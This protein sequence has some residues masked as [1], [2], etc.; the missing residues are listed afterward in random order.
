VILDQLEMQSVAKHY[1]ERLSVSEHLRKLLKHGDAKQFA[2][3]ALGIS[4]P[5]ANYSAKEHGLGPRILS[6]VRPTAVL[7][8]ATKLAQSATPLEMVESIYRENIPYL[9]ISVGSEIAMMI[10]P[11]K[12]WV[13]NTRSVWAHLLV[14]HKFDYR[15]ANEELKL[16]RD[17]DEDSEMAYKKWKAI[18]FEMRSN[19]VELGRRVEKRAAKQKISVGAA[20]N[21]WFDAIANALYEAK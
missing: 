16:Y 7:N 1:D 6:A 11:E 19:L 4:E 3:V 10:E 12:F 8:L 5:H 9:K 17:D 15:K 18:Y 2:L 13:A 14:K 21:I 20:K